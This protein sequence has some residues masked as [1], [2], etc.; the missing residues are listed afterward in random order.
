MILRNMSNPK[1][2]SLS[3]TEKGGLYYALGVG[4]EYC[5]DSVGMTLD[6]TY[7]HYTSSSIL[8]SKPLRRRSSGELVYG[9]FDELLKI[10]HGIV[11][12]TLGCKFKL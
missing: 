9:M 3:I 8:R 2:N 4:Y 11:G 5:K 10:N 7:S 12:V 6:V 1:H